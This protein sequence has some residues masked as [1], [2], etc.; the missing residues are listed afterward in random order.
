MV[1][2]LAGMAKL[3]FFFIREKATFTFVAD[4]KLFR[5]FLHETEKNKILIC[6]FDE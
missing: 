4:W 3:I 5:N 1:M 6:S 2:E